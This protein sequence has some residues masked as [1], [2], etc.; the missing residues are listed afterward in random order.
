[1][2]NILIPYALKDGN[3]VHVSQVEQGEIC[4]CICPEC[5]ETLIA[6]KGEIRRHHFRHKTDKI[7]IGAL[8]TTIHLL[9]KKV[10]KKNKTLCVPDL[11]ISYE[12][13]VGIDSSLQEDKYQNLYIKSRIVT[14]LTVEEEIRLKNANIQPDAI[15]YEDNSHI[16]I[17]FYNTHKIDDEKKEIYNSINESCIEINLQSLKNINF[18]DDELNDEKAIQGILSNPQNSKWISYHISKELKD[19]VFKSLNV[20]KEDKVELRQNNDI[21]KLQENQWLLR[22]DIEK[23]FLNQCVHQFLDYYKETL[24]LPQYRWDKD[25]MFFRYLLKNPDIV[26]II[27]NPSENYWKG[28]VYGPYYKIY[29]NIPSLNINK[30]YFAKKREL[31]L[32]AACLFSKDDNLEFNNRYVPITIDE[33]F[34]KMV[35]DSFCKNCPYYEMNGYF[36]FCSKSNII[37]KETFVD[38]QNCVYTSNGIELLSIPNGIIEY[39]VREGT[40]KIDKDVIKCCKTL[41]KIILPSTIQVIPENMVF[42]T[43]IKKVNLKDCDFYIGRDYVN[44][45]YWSNKVISLWAEKEKDNNIE[46][47]IKSCLKKMGR[48]QT[49]YEKIQKLNDGKCAQIY[50]F[51]K[52]IDPN[53]IV[54]EWEEMIENKYVFL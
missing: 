3:L 17:E 26:N 12:K 32:C 52:E 2:N 25:C 40:R 19:K 50:L 46:K 21:I 54:D 33:R 51:Y 41:K 28:E 37:H 7:C 24:S 9:A 47:N 27:V 18:S 4:G 15:G 31:I 16:C 30:T 6:I 49:S 36:E 38:N 11:R 35:E 5:G 20:T 22:Q 1:M 48:C 43:N 44:L 23:D 10:L 45:E 14:F 53:F 39:S 34:G 42:D 8:E 13:I 29:S